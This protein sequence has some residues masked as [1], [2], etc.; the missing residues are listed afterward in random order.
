MPAHPPIPAAGTVDNKAKLAGMLKGHVLQ[1]SLQM[2]GCR[3]VQ[4]AL[5]VLDLETQCEIIAELDGHVMR[6]VRDQV[7]LRAAREVLD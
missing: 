7:C 6:C 1:L 3:V 2:Y 5:E 4:K